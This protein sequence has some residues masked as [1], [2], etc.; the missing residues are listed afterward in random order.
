MDRILLAVDGSEH[1]MR[2]ATLAGELSFSLGAPVDVINV[3]QDGTPVVPGV[4]H[5]YAHLEHIDLTRRDLLRSMGTEVLSLA[6]MKVKEAG[7][8]VGNITKLDD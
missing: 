8:D 3:V 7:G 6:A 1:S 4:V 2:A 5:E